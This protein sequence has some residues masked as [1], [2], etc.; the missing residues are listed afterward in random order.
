MSDGGAPRAAKS[1]DRG[2]RQQVAQ[3]GMML[4]RYQLVSELGEGGMATVFGARDTKLERD[5]AVK[6]MFPHLARRQ[7]AASRFKREARAA[8]GLDHEHILRVFDVGGGQIE[9][10][11]LV[12]PYIVLE[13]IDGSSLDDFFQ[14]HDPP[15]S[16]VVA[17]IGVA[18]CRGLDQ[19]HASGIVHRDIK[20]ANVMVTKKGRLVLADFGVARVGDDDSVVTR[21]GAVLGTPAYMS[22]E[23]ASGEEV[24]ARSDL[25][26]LGA[27]LY[28]LATGSVPYGGSSAQVISGILDGKKV[29]AEQRDA[30]IGRELSR[31][32]DRLME[33]ELSD[34]YQSAQDA[35]EALLE[36]VTGGGEEDSEA[37]LASY[38]RDPGAQLERSRDGIVSA[39]LVR[40]RILSLQ[41]RAPAAIA[42]AERVLALSPGNVQ[43]QALCDSLGQGRK[44]RRRLWLAIFGPMIA[45]AI[46]GAVFW[47]SRPGP[48]STYA[49]AAHS[50]AWIPVADA[51][52]SVLQTPVAVQY[53]AGARKADAHSED[54]ATGRSHG[55]P[56]V[57]PRKRGGVDAAVVATSLAMADAALSEV[58]VAQPAM[59]IVNILPWC[60]VWIDGAKRERASKNTTYQLAPG[61]YSVECKQASTNMSWARK[62]TLSA[63]EVRTLLGSVLPPVTIAVRL[64]KG[65]SVT[66]GSRRIAD[67][68]SAV[69]AAGR[70]RTQVWKSGKPRG[71]AKFMDIRT[72]CILRDE[73]NLV[74]SSR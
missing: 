20:P 22:P 18:L 34:R 61:T 2:P 7:E 28:R 70:H 29:P 1:L 35:A 47:G 39:N 40:A 48:I 56:R 25:Y 53:D 69:I 66:V 51:S 14:E 23:Q 4:G 16:E 6:V 68:E 5:V 58:P 44:A 19:A 26:S 42:I 37:L 73:P 49:D 46:V 55:V 38:V 24:D 9:G 72:S 45:T 67:G 21:T 43:A 50:D 15:L 54:A 57:G 52:S 17:A 8:A 11:V 41:G 12:P 27:T 71:N 36:I 13:L 60:D 65:E 74:C 64:S 33:T 10:D 3:V 32:I 31:V 63:G 59:L 62:V 30:R